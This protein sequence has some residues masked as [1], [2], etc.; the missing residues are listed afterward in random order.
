MLR[1]PSVGS[2][3]GR[4]FPHTI[5]QSRPIFS[6][7]SSRSTRYGN[8]SVQFSSIQ[9]G[10]DFLHGHAFLLIRPFLGHSRNEQVLEGILPEQAETAG[11]SGRGIHH[12]SPPMGRHS[13]SVVATYSRHSSACGILHDFDWSQRPCLVRSRPPRI[14]ACS[15]ILLGF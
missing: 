12:R 5:L 14:P 8:H 15:T 6:P 13:R 3:R 11:H 4:I 7:F 2:V 10:L 9:P 1:C